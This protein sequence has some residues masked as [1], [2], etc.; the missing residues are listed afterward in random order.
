M[1]MAEI[2]K[3][4]GGLKPSDLKR[5]LA[6]VRQAEDERRRRSRKR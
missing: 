4:G 1:P 6:D 3:M 5:F 2:E